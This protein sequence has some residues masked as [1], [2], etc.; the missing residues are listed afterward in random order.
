MRAE[1]NAP[2]AAAPLDGVAGLRAVAVA[3][4]LRPATSP[5]LRALAE[6]LRSR[7][8]PALLVPGGDPSLRSAARLL[9]D[10]ARAGDSVRAER[11]LI[12]LRRVWCRLPEAQAVPDPERDA[13]WDRLVLLCCEEF[14]AGGAGAPPASGPALGSAAEPA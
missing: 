10:E 7:A 12:A 11:L 14:Y 4:G 3:N 5:G 1:L 9:A 13:L 8:A 2:P 6:A